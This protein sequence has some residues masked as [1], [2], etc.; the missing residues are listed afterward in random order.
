M[1]R[2]K[3]VYRIIKGHQSNKCKFQFKIDR[4]FDYTT[5]KAIVIKT[6]EKIIKTRFGMRYSEMQRRYT[7]I[8]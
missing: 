8:I 7:L 1:T 5:F 4:E 2:D 3:A 6:L